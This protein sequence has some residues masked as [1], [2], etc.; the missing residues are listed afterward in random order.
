MKLISVNIFRIVTLCKNCGTKRFFV[1]RLV[2]LTFIGP[3]KDK[4]F[5]NHIDNSGLNNDLTNL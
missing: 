4:P 3:S 5:V 2:L 1:H